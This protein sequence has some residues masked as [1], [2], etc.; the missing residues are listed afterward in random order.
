MK[1]N[2]IL[3]RSVYLLALFLFS[4]GMAVAQNFYYDPATSSELIHEL[5]SLEN[6]GRVMY[7]AAHPDDENTRLISWL[8]NE[9]QV[10]VVYLSLTRGDGGQNLVGPE[11]REG[12]GVIRTQELLQA[13]KTD[14]GE[15][16]FTRANDFGYSKTPEESFKIWDREKVLADV[17]WAI[18]KKRPDVIITRFSAEKRIGRATHGHHTAS[19]ILASEAFDLAADPDAFP[20]QLKYVE[21]WQPK[22]LFWNTSWWF[23][24]SKE[25]LE[26]EINKSPNKYL[27][28]SV[29]GYIQDLGHSCSEIASLSRSRHKSQ[30]FGSTPDRGPETEYLM[31]IKGSPVTNDIFEGIDITWKRAGLESFEKRYDKITSGIST[32]KPEESLEA[33]CALYTEIKNAETSQTGLRDHLVERLGDIMLKIS[34]L[35][36]E[37]TVDQE[38]LSV[39]EE[40]AA[41]IRIINRLPGVEVEVV[42]MMSQHESARQNRMR[43]LPRT[44]DGFQEVSFTRNLDLS[45]AK[46]SQPYWLNPQATTGMYHVDDQTLIGKPEND[47]Q[48]VYNVGIRMYGAEITK[49]IPVIYSTTDP[50][51]GEVKYPPLITPKVMVNLEEDVYIFPDDQPREIGMEVISGENG[52]LEGYAELTL[53]SG[54][55]SDPAFQKVSLQG[56]GQRAVVRFTVTPPKG[57]QDQKISGYFKLD[58]DNQIY[59]NGFQHIKYDHIPPQAIFPGCEARLVKV[60]LAVDERVKKIGY[61]MGAG[62]LVPDALRNIGL[63]VELLEA[64]SLLQDGID[65]YDAVVI[66]IRAFNT[67]KEM[68]YVNDALTKF[69]KDG[70]VVVVQYNTSH[71]L[72]T[73]SI[74]PYPLTLSRDRVTEEDAKVDIIAGKDQIVNWP[75]KITSSDFDGWVQERGLYFPSEWDSRYIPV[76]KMADTGEEPSSGSL[77]VAYVGKGKFVYTGI[78]FFRE[79][80]AGV[81]GAYR[82]MANL[83][84]AP[85]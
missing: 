46:I 40:I 34:R 27:K 20:E 8:T 41:N 61:V 28:I 62:D 39:G 22:R 32:E 25:R 9:R 31:L 68:A 44:L 64:S 45:L 2:R 36:M 80:P 52:A 63:D 35:Y 60:G 57:A 84:A 21:T 72:V 59:G 30:G 82:L 54:W 14:G 47:L 3:I 13:R 65:Q 74:G 16:M 48:L 38:L 58:N 71:R 26:E 81:P 56:K 29:G 83:L 7:I 42:S 12:L 67:L 76:L 19:A 53:P 18:R 77:L 5:K 85:K 11:I 43:T 69:A 70:G 75:N 17:V 66:G 49:T 79:L 24:G 4:G 51:K 73:D 50:V 23:Y 78:S 33:L 6:M 15:Q 10:E 55:K 1:H 37:I